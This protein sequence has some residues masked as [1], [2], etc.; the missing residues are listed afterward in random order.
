[1]I[2][3][4]FDIFR[5]VE[6]EVDEIA[7]RYELHY[8]LLE[9]KSIEYLG[10]KYIV[11]FDDPINHAK[12]FFKLDPNNMDDFKRIVWDWVKEIRGIG[13]EETVKE[14]EP[15]LVEIAK[16]LRIAN[17]LKIID[18]RLKTAPHYFGREAAK[19]I[20]RLEKELSSNDIQSVE[21]VSEY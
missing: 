5:R 16:Q 11:K 17:E 9:D 14:P 4:R 19:D 7:R 2:P 18:I 13:N 6:A 8:E 12:E 10:L 1:M 21:E 3:T 20:D 15:L